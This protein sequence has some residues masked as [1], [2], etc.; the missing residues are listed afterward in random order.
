MRKI[1]IEIPTGEF[2]PVGFL[3]IELNAVMRTVTRATSARA[4]IKPSPSAIDA[5]KTPPPPITKLRISIGTVPTSDKMREALRYPRKTSRCPI[6]TARRYSRS[7]V[8]LS[9]TNRR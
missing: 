4:V 2:I 7:P 6:P 8:F 5:W 9:A 3:C 1:P